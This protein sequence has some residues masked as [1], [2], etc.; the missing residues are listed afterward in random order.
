VSGDLGGEA[1]PR[2]LHLIAQTYRSHAQRQSAI[3]RIATPSIC[4]V[5]LGG[6]FVLG[7]CLSLFLPMVQLLKD[8]SL[9]TGA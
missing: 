5:L 4:G 9:P 8:V 6:T 2:I 1:A 3:W 7:Y